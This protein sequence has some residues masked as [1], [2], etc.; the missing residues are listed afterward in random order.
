MSMVS[1]NLG[2]AGGFNLAAGLGFSANLLHL[3]LSNNI[4]GDLAGIN[5]AA[6][7]TKGNFDI[8][9]LNLSKN[10][11]TDKCGVKIAY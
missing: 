2:Q 4:L 3:N 1:C 11:F 10:S 9:N 7:F 8:E 5:I 6:T